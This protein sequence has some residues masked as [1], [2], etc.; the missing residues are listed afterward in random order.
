MENERDREIISR[1]KIEVMSKIIE[2]FASISVDLAKRPLESFV[3]TVDICLR[4]AMINVLKVA[5]TENF[6]ELS[7]DVRFAAMTE[8]VGGLNSALA[9]DHPY[10]ICAVCFEDE[11]DLSF[12]CMMRNKIP[13]MH[14]LLTRGIV[15]I[16]RVKNRE[17]LFSPDLKFSVEFLPAEEEFNF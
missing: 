15:P 3:R 17:A 13:G 7:F 10:I 5:G 16:C 4:T 9:L 1:F 11:A 2:T 8:M 12:V 14:D 6:E